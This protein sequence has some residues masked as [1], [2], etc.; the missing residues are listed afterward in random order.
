MG[1]FGCCRNGRRDC[2]SYEERTKFVSSS[3]NPVLLLQFLQPGHS[4]NDV[5][6]S[7]IAEMCPQ[8][9]LLSI[10]NMHTVPKNSS[11]VT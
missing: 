2:S 3:V 5:F 4:P 10:I 9:L 11:S 7:E 6:S 1:W 8:R